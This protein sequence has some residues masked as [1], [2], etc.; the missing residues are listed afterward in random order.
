MCELIN[1]LDEK[2]FVGYKFVFRR[3]GTEDFYSS[4]TGQKY[5]KGWL[6]K[7]RQGRPLS[8][9]WRILCL[10][11]FREGFVGMTAVFEHYSDARNVSY[12]K[13]PKDRDKFVAEIWRAE[14]SGKLWDGRYCNDPIVAGRKIKFLE[15]ERVL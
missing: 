9:G 14:V 8:D 7:L 5:T 10:S 2:T 13:Q 12:G 1:K 6:P 15:C 4:F 3:V 11:I